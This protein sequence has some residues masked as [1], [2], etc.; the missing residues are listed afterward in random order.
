MSAA[1][2]PDAR[3]DLNITG[4]RMVDPFSKGALKYLQEFED[5]QRRARKSGVKTEVGD[6]KSLRHHPLSVRQ[7]CN[8]ETVPSP[9]YCSYFRIMTKRAFS[10]PV[11]LQ[12]AVAYDSVRFFAVALDYLLTHTGPGVKLHRLSC[13]PSPSPSGAGAATK[14]ISG[15][16]VADTI[17]DVSVEEKPKSNVLLL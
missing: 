7:F 6:P 1:S 11:Q 8:F 5:V 12:N 10:R 4:F 3:L 17:R 14:W 13:D 16:T 2:F 15:G 9:Y